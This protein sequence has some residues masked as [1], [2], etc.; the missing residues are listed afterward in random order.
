M[1]ENNQG[2]DHQDNI[3]EKSGHDEEVNFQVV[4]EET[5]I[6]VDYL[7]ISRFEMVVSDTDSRD[8]G[9]NVSGRK[10]ETLPE[11]LEVVYEIYE[12]S[13]DE[14]SLIDGHILDML[15]PEDISQSKHEALNYRF[16]DATTL[17]YQDAEKDI[18][19][20]G[21]DDVIDLLFAEELQLA[22]KDL[23]QK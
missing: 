8:T 5:L 17:G 22:L 10:P 18:E 2:D 4:N 13:Y 21:V 19:K 3:G 14:T 12:V 11:I 15:V 7:T 1:V 23:C 16:K 9:Y 6:E 20:R